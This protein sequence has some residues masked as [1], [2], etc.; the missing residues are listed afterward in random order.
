MNP[1]ND[2]TIV[3][4]NDDEVLANI[5]YKQDIADNVKFVSLKC[6][7]GLSTKAF[8]KVF[9]YIRKEKPDI[10]HA[11]CNVLQLYLSAMLCGGTKYVHT[12]HNLA[13]VCLQFRWCES[14]NRRLYCSR[15]QP[16]TISNICKQSFVELY[17]SND[18]VCITNGREPLNPSNVRPADVNFLEEDV[19]TFIH[20]A[21]CAVQKNQDRLF[22]AFDRLREEGLKFHLLVLGSGY[23]G[24][25]KER[26]EKNPQIH[27]V[28]ERKN[29]ADYMALADFFVLSSDFEGLPLT[30]L[31][32]MSVGVTPISTPAGGVA[33]VIED[34]KN[35][36]MTKGFDGEEFFQ[37]V[38]Q[39]IRER[40]KFD[41]KAIKAEYEAKYSMKVCAGKYYKVYEKMMELKL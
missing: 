27:I 5:H 1:E 26:Y 35:G 17:G 28:G 14:I 13:P 32:A 2:V 33:D 10:V 41:G 40:G 38:K 30:L 19:P 29:V 34:G 36:Y 20:V 18:A 7:T 12:L 9:K 11:H 23:D 22:A 16:I 39:A 21:R 3:M 37:K 24:V 25:W 31:E 15:I 6:K 4:I 8:W